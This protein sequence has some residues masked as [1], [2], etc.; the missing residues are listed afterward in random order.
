MVA[1]GTS[2]PEL[3]TTI[4]A[5]RKKESQLSIGNIIGA[6]II[7]LSLILP[8]C[9][10][11]SGS[12]FTVSPQCLQIDFPIC[13]LIT[14]LALLPIVISEKSSRVQGILILVFYGAYLIIAI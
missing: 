7:D 11:I 2:L 9:A 14:L 4:T 13:F 8:L 6:N 12:S 1:I 5:I 3:V 10:L